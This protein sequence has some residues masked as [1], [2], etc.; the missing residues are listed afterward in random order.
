MSYMLFYLPIF[1][2][3]LGIHDFLTCVD[4][5]ACIFRGCH[6]LSDII[7]VCLDTLQFCLWRGLLNHLKSNKYKNMNGV[8]LS[9]VEYFIC[10]LNFSSYNLPN[11]HDNMILMLDVNLIL[12]NKK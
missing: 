10:H 9:F 5:N 3:E 8:T 1:R 2:K 6:K 4:N 7:R 12:T 11:L